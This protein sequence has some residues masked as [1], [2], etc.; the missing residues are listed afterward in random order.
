M[1]R[2]GGHSYKNQNLPS[3][4]LET[5]GFKINLTRINSFSNLRKANGHH[6]NGNWQT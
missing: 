1:E 3:I 5:C 2:L 4:N 6:R